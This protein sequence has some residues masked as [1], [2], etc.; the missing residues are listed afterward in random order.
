MGSI[1]AARCSDQ[2]KAQDAFRPTSG[3]RR[4]PD[5]VSRPVSSSKLA[6]ISLRTWRATGAIRCTAF[7]KWASLS[8]RLAEPPC[9]PSR[10]SSKWRIRLVMYAGIVLCDITLPPTNNQYLRDACTTYR[11]RRGH[12]LPSLVSAAALDEDHAGR[13]TCAALHNPLFFRGTFLFV[14]TTSSLAISCDSRKPN[15]RPP[16]KPR[17]YPIRTIPQLDAAAASRLRRFC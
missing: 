13:R 4:S 8:F 15:L 2:L 3:V 17:P 14:T 7:S 6:F 10:R 5:S 12:L 11:S 16:H 9:V 1:P